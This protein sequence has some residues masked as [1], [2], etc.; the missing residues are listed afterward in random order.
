MT[1]LPPVVERT[2]MTIMIM[3]VFLVGKKKAR[4]VP[5]IFGDDKRNFCQG[6]L[7]STQT[8]DPRYLCY[9]NY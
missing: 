8:C 6:I 2:K 9:C 3:K 7:D 5:I 4:I 1:M